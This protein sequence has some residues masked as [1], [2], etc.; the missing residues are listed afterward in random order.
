MLTVRPVTADLRVEV[1]GDPH[2]L[3]VEIEAEVDRI[4]EA[5]RALSPQLFDGPL[6]SI[7]VADGDQI[8]GTM[9][10]YRRFV[11][12]RR[13]PALAAQLAVR[14]LGVTGLHRCRDGVV[15]CRRAG[16]VEM[17]AE[18]W[19][20]SASGSVDGRLRTSDGAID[21]A[22]QI[23]EELAQ[24]TGVEAAAIPAPPTPFAC[25]D[26]DQSLVTDIGM[27]I[28][29]DLA[30]ADILARFDRRET[31]EYEAV[32]VVPQRRLEAFAAEID[33]APVSRALLRAAEP[34]LAA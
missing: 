7:S 9:T 31:R 17:D 12:Q 16:D 6:F 22:A 27:L 14:P 3:P 21:L 8:R 18:R 30:E 34:L 28:V 13:R 33:L 25:V 4:W 19:E 29:S 20:L 32:A 2:P 23:L 5:E 15:F 24:E 26:D 1:D 11:A 10:G